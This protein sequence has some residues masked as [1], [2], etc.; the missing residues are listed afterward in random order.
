MKSE[1]S[2]ED[3]AGRVNVTS[4][5]LNSLDISISY[6][7]I[8]WL[9]HYSS[10]ISFMEGLHNL[11]DITDMSEKEVWKRSHGL[12]T[13]MQ[14]NFEIGDVSP[15]DYNEIGVADRLVTQFS[16]GSKYNPAFV[17]SSDALNAVAATLGKLGK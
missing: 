4:E 2:V 12:D 11:G 8:L 10:H 1:Y 5:R 15:E 3:A 14:S 6:N 9:T 13:L 17:H 7:Y 16:W